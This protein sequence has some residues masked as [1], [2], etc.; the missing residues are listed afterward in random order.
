MPVE[1]ESHEQ[2]GGHSR[3][4]EVKHLYSSR[5]PSKAK[6]EHG[7]TRDPNVPAPQ[8]LSLTEHSRFLSPVDDAAARREKDAWIVI[9][10]KAFLARRQEPPT[11]A[12]T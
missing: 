5:P 7:L 10:S 1:P 9:P 8:S 11:D 3:A 6:R 12:A 4:V 2:S